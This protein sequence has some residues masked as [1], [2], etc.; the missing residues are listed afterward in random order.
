L[1]FCLFTD[2]PAQDL[3]KRTY[4]TDIVPGFPGR[5]GKKREYPLVATCAGNSLYTERIS[6]L[7]RDKPVPPDMQLQRKVDP[8]PR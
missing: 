4:E 3:G 6:G 5:G 7:F 2:V 1:S 8:S